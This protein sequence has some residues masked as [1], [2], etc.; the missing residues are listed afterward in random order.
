MRERTLRRED[1]G[2]DRLFRGGPPSKLPS[3]RPSPAQAPSFAY[4]IENLVPPGG[5]CAG[6]FP[7]GLDGCLTDCGQARPRGK[8]AAAPLHCC[9]KEVNSMILLGCIAAVAVCYGVF[10]LCGRAIESGVR[11]GLVE[12]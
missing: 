10:Y 12:R 6:E 5:A 7:L 8:P 4:G 11:L 9:T 3:V 1:L 2:G